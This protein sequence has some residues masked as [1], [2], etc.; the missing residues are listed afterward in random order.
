MLLL[1]VII[2]GPVIAFGLPFRASEL[3]MWTVLLKL[4]AAQSVDVADSDEIS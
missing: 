4:W 1:I 3:N 2:S